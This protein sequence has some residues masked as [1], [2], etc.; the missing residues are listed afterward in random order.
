MID[1]REFL[2]AAA[3]GAAL[4]L[5]GARRVEHRSVSDHGEDPVPTS[6]PAA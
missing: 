5:A 6:P 2:T 3:A 1:R 4:T